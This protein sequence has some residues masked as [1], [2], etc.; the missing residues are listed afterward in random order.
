MQQLTLLNHIAR[1]YRVHISRRMIGI[2]ILYSLL[3]DACNARGPHHPKSEKRRAEQQQH[4]N[5]H[6]AFEA[7]HIQEDIDAQQLPTEK[8][9]EE[10]SEE[11]RNYMFFKVHD[12]DGN[13]KLDGLEIFY[14]A[15]HHAASEHD[16]NHV[17]SDNEADEGNDNENSQPS[18]DSSL[19]LSSD[20]SSLKLLELDEN[21]QIVNTNFNHIIDVLDNFLSLADLNNDGYLN[22]AE[23][24]AAVKLGNAMTEEQ[25]PEL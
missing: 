6:L 7:Q 18:N 10:M 11:E 21:G 8:K 20:A 17:H 4:I 2:F 13:D 24:A 9:V 14:S 12:L 15:T 19:D 1:R 23:Y 3:I 16:H 5:E 25:N 22:Y